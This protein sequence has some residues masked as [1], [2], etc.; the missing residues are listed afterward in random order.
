MMNYPKVSIII[1]NW[2]GLEDT[3]ECLE[4][5][6]KITYPNYEVILVDNGSERNDAKVLRERFGNYIHLIEND[7]NYGFAGGN[8]IGI[9]YALENLSPN[10][11]LL[12]NNDTVVAPDFLARLVKFAESNEKFGIVGPKIYYYDYD[13]RK[14]VI[15]FAGGKFNRRLGKTNHLGART[16]DKGQFETIRK[17]DYITGCAFLIKTEILNKI[18]LLDEDYFNH[19][20]DLDFCIRAEKEQY[21]C[22]YVPEAKIWHKVSQSSGGRIG[23]I[24]LYYNT[25]NRA[26]FMKKNAHLFDQICFSPFYLIRFVLIPLVYC[27]LKLRMSECLVVLGGFFDFLNGVSGEAKNC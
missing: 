27:I 21:Y 26:L 5:L 20:E 17:V 15:W 22:F 19:F 9:R 10:Y 8:N 16:I 12:L 4:S 7:R 18:G 1:L 25:R 13:G 3:I 24:S 11:V 6:R 23:H 2:N 14:D